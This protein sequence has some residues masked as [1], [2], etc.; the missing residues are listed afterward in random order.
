MTNMVKMYSEKLKCYATY[1]LSNQPSFYPS[2]FPE[3]VKFCTTNI[4]NSVIVIYK[5]ALYP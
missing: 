1:I 2:Q 5:N 4:D 3:H